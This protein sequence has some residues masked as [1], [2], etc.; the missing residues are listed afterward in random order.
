MVLSLKKTPL[1]SHVDTV[2]I[3]SP[4]QLMLDT[5]QYDV[6]SKIWASVDFNSSKAKHLTNT[7]ENKIAPT[8][9]RSKIAYILFI[10]GVIDLKTAK[11]TIRSEEFANEFRGCCVM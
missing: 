3:A 11:Q 1:G 9:T 6:V 10:R 8:S 2:L 5:C 7:L 4:Y